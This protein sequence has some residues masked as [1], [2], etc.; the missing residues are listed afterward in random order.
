M[1]DIAEE[2]SRQYLLALRASHQ[3]VHIW[4]KYTPPTM[5]YTTHF[6][7]F[8]DFYTTMFFGCPSDGVKYTTKYPSDGVKPRWCIFSHLQI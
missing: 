6:L 4:A 5:F 7:T 1:V 8:L 2:P 3:M